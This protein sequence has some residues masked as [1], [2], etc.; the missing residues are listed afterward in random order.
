[1]AARPA[2]K[3]ILFDFAYVLTLAWIEIVRRSL[4]HVVRL[5]L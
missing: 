1:M 4:S 5:L 2:K 3:I